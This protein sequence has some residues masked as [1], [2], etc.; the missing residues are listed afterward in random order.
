[1]P[2]G[3]DRP[4]KR[5]ASL[6]SVSALDGVVVRTGDEEGFDSVGDGYE[7]VRGRPVEGVTEGDDGGA[8]FEFR[9][10][11]AQFTRL[12]RPRPPR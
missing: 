7:D 11:D 2:G 8:R 4:S 1:M 6:E 3:A 5:A 12:P 9:G 10:L